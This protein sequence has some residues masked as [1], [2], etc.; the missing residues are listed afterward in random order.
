MLVFI[1]LLYVNS[2]IKRCNYFV[3][4]EYLEI[5]FYSAVLH[6]YSTVNLEMK[7]GRK[8]SFNA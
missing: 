2:T 7:G 1:A 8:F 4:D 5:N 3:F 6:F